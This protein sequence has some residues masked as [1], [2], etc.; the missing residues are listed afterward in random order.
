MSKPIKGVLNEDED[1]SNYM[2]ELTF[3][4]A[5]PKQETTKEV[6]N[7]TTMGRSAGQK[8]EHPADELAFISQGFSKDDNSEDVGL[9]KHE[10]NGENLVDELKFVSHLDKSDNDEKKSHTYQDGQN[11]GGELNQSLSDDLV[12]LSNSTL[13]EKAQANTN[14]SGAHEMGGNLADELAFISQDSPKEEEIEDAGS[15]RNEDNLVDELNFV[16]QLDTS[17]DEPVQE[18]I[19][20][21]KTTQEN[22]V[23]ELQFLSNSPTKRKN[24]EELLSNNN[25]QKKRK[26]K[27]KQKV[28]FNI[29]S[30]ISTETKSNGS[31]G[32]STTSNLSTDQKNPSPIKHITAVFVFSYIAVLMTF[33]N[34]RIGL[35]LFCPYDDELGT[36]IVMEK[37]EQCPV[38][39]LNEQE[40]DH[41][42]ESFWR[43]EHEKDEEDLFDYVPAPAGKRHE[44]LC[45]GT[46]NVL[47]AVAEL[48]HPT[49]HYKTTMPQV[50][51]H[52]PC[53]PIS[54]PEK[55][56]K[57]KHPLKKFMSK[58]ACIF[59]KK[60]EQ[61]ELSV[62]EPSVDKFDWTFFVSA[63]LDFN[64]TSKQLALAKKV[65]E[66]V[67][68]NPKLLNQESSFE[69]IMEQV[70]FGG[71]HS[72]WFP[73]KDDW[74]KDMEFSGLRLIAAY[75]KIMD[76]PE[77]SQSAHKYEGV[78]LQFPPHSFNFRIEFGDKFSWIRYLFRRMPSR[79][80]HYQYS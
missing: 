8:T 13:P 50:H 78:T 36:F 4:S 17:V 6:L 37:V 22:L 49:V 27:Q 39:I 21:E 26:K 32:M 45:R 23:D 76:W 55:K 54:K 25:V 79:L 31:N 30:S 20:I 52:S 63:P 1:S 70:K 35:R 75:M 57:K 71:K 68:K 9:R 18:T 5:Q 44:I 33:A 16:S 34:L 64:L 65:A 56:S 38:R 12:F 14:N 7:G 10:I 47:H 66:N 74:D 77:V 69:E 59:R 28:Q 51:T 80:C 19:K 46:F 29:D 58:I 73:E 60:A 72:W 53:P 3:I 48:L 11:S 41:C 42:D 2:N 15:K 43:K 61:I 67:Q 24:G 40:D 62:E